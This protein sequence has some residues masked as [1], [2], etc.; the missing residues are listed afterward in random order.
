M[1]RRG[2][3]EENES[4]GEG[5]ENSSVSYGKTYI[6]YTG[7]PV[8]FI[9]RSETL[10]GSWPSRGIAERPPREPSSIYASAP[11]ISGYNYT[12]DKPELPP[13]AV[14]LRAPGAETRG[15]DNRLDV[16]VSKL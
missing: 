15:D 5:E 11:Y 8:Y 1:G 13:S 10:I 16:S 14:P 4:E 2:E 3:D 12:R 6:S 7:Y 9:F